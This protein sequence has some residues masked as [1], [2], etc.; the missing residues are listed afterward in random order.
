MN[1]KAVESAMSLDPITGNVTL[2]AQT[3]RG[4][5]AEIPQETLPVDTLVAGRGRSPTRERQ[6]PSEV[7]SYALDSLFRERP[8]LGDTAIPLLVKVEPL[9]EQA[10]VSAMH[11]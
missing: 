5:S 7:E 1:L 8:P 4:A 6:P 9:V 10:A 3:R 11:Y 2:V